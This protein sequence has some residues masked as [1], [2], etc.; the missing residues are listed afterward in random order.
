MKLLSTLTTLIPVIRAL[1]VRDTAGTDLTALEKRSAYEVGVQLF[2]AGDCSGP[3]AFPDRNHDVHSCNTATLT[4]GVANGAR[5]KGDGTA[6]GSGCMTV[7]ETHLCAGQS[8]TYTL[9][10]D[11]CINFDDVHNGF[12]AQCV[13]VG[14]KNGDCGTTVESCLKG[15]LIDGTDKC[16]AQFGA[17]FVREERGLLFTQLTR[18]SPTTYP[19]DFYPRTHILAHL[20]QHNRPK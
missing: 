10:A 5:V 16:K 11:Q 1:V 9:E 8:K 12:R 2:Q 7:F 4:N 13:V 3:T 14:S 20:S 6:H 15:G 19:R 18:V 17:V